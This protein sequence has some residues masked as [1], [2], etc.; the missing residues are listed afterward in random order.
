MADVGAASDGG[1]DFVRSEKEKLKAKLK[2]EI[3][4]LWRNNKSDKVVHLYVQMP[5]TWRYLD[6]ARPEH[7]YDTQ[8]LHSVLSPEDALCQPFGKRGIHDQLG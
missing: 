8:V 1:D 2:D 3:F 7:R 5:D 4:S 6:G